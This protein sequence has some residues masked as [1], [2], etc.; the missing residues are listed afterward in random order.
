MARLDLL[1]PEVHAGL[2]VREELQV[3]LDLLDLMAGPDVMVAEDSQ[4]H[5]DP[6][7]HVE[8]LDLVDPL[9]HEG[10]LD[11]GVNLVKLEH[12]E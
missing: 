7:D 9:D 10:S 3:D 4:D 1:D 2:L 12:L 11:L 8:S 5:P 6:L